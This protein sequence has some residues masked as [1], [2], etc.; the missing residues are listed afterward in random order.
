[1]PLGSVGR[2]IAKEPPTQPRVMRPCLRWDIIDAVAGDARRPPRW[3]WPFGVG[4]TVRAV[5]GH[6]DTF[7][8]AYLERTKN[9]FT[10]EGVAPMNDRQNRIYERALDLASDDDWS[11]EAAVKE[12]RR[13]AG[14]RQT[15]LGPAEVTA[16]IGGRFLDLEVENRAQRLLA[17]AISGEPIRA[18]TNEERQRF[19]AVGEFAELGPDAA[20]N[21]LVAA[22]PPLGEVAEELIRSSAGSKL[23]TEDLRNLLERVQLLVGP[24]SGSSD[25]LIGSVYARTFA[26]DRLRLLLWRP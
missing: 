12:L 18:V 8:A 19:D 25:P 4:S 15:D 10:P 24:G 6:R 11:D 3:L 9:E 16:R 22:V 1:M 14:R 2:R 21:R 23:T 5:T 26:T 17:S 7:R 13:L 20:W